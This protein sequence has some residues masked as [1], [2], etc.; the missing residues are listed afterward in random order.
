MDAFSPVPPTWAESAIHATQFCCP[1]CGAS[2]GQAQA[3]WINRRAPV[4][5]PN[6]RR[7][8]QEFYHCGQCG[9]PWWAWSSDRPPTPGMADGTGELGS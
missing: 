2:S 6:H 8:W 4:Y 9:N 3:A 7:K 1:R 5:T